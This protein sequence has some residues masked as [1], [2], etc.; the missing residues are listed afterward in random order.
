VR[1]V[2]ANHT[3][4][5]D[6]EATA[7]DAGWARGLWRLATSLPGNEVFRLNVCEKTLS[8]ARLPAP[9]EGLSIAHLTDFHMSGRIAPGYFRE[10]VERTNALAP[11]LVAITGD[12]VDVPAC[13]A[14]IPETL[15]Q[16]IAPLG[17]YFV[18]GNHDREV[19]LEA[20]RRALAG[21]GLRDLG[22]R[23][24][25]LEVAGETV[26]LAG[27]ELPWIHPAATV[28]PRNDGENES[29]GLRILL[30]H[31][32]DQFAWAQ[33]RDFDLMLAGHTHGGQI[34]FPLVGAL[35]APS[36]YGTKYAAGVFY[37]KPTLMHVSRGVSGLTP[38]R[39]NCPPEV[40][41]LRLTQEAVV[42][43]ASRAAPSERES[44]AAWT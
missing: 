17:V 40:A 6:L 33:R 30:A 4:G 44:F 14:W 29:A 15:G 25:R 26:L 43:P 19:D 27:N 11:D 16:L 38:V 39:Y 3:T 36:L 21:A 7:R 41:V 42:P 13:I 18:L 5:V 24:Q 8:I 31:S 37:K 28:P 32:P 35:L 1:Q 20:L 9:L 34:C 23:A 10:I 12:L 22:G 2:L